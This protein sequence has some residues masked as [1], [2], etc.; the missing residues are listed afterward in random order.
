MKQYVTFRVDE[1]LL[2]IDVL[3]VREVNSVLDITPV[4]KAP[5]YVRGLV[6]L[7]G[8]TVTVFDLGICLGLPPRKITEQSHN[9]VL[10]QDLVGLLVDSIGNMVQCGA[11][12]VEP[13][14][15]NAGS[16]RG[17]FVDGVLKLD[18]ELLVILDTKRLLECSG[19]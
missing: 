1:D 6:N 10:K 18:H 5:A 19:V 2:G 16:I 11:L 3:M 12:D 15:A 17:K 4:P 14:P 8:Q 9:V 13:P 7:R